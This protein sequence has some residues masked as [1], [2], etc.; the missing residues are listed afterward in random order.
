MRGSVWFG[1]VGGKNKT[2]NH[3]VLYDFMIL[4]VSNI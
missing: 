2:F 4:H 1:T 3:L